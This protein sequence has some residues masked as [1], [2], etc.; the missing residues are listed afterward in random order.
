MLLRSITFCLVLATLPLTVAGF[1]ANKGVNHFTTNVKKMVATSFDGVDF[2]RA[3]DCADHFGK[4][5]LKEIEKLR[6][7]LHTERLQLFLDKASG[8]TPSLSASDEMKHRL[9]EE[10][11]NLQLFLLK[12]ESFNKAGEKEPIM[13][14]DGA[15]AMKL[16]EAVSVNLFNTMRY[17]FRF[18]VDEEE[19]EV[20]MMCF[21]VLLLTLIPQFIA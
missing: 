6:N 19:M 4:C 21:A 20:M 12:D 14:M 15:I 3:S 5:S 11:L 13:P 2:E 9:I 16:N 8:Y 1:V 18:V 7:S 17:P 10:D